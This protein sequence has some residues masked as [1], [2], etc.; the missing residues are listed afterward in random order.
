MGTGLTL[1]TN[2][3]A[4]SASL[5]N[6]HVTPVRGPTCH[7]SD[8]S[9]RPP[10]RIEADYHSQSRR[11]CGY[12]S[13]SN[14]RHDAAAPATSKPLIRHKGAFPSSRACSQHSRRGHGWS[15]PELESGRRCRYEYGS[16][17]L[18]PW[19]PVACETFAL[20]SHAQFYARLESPTLYGQNLSHECD[21]TA[22][23]GWLWC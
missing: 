11:W 20:N 13:C 3:S 8:S 16:K 12:A 10:S 6:G 23:K 14:R 7:R 21:L 22:A 9:S 18:R 17:V 4:I 2:L 1:K 19:C 5:G 15:P